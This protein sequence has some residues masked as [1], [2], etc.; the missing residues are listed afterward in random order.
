MQSPAV[1]AGKPVDLNLG[2]DAELWYEK[3]V[4]RIGAE[5]ND[6][7]LL[8]STTYQVTYCFVSTKTTATRVS[9][10]GQ[11]YGRSVS[12]EGQPRRACRCF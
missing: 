8:L 12:A 2:A 9:V 5:K 10:R 11:V 3:I 7:G 4:Q 1:Q 6:K